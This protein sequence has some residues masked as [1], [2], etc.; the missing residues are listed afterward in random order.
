MKAKFGHA[1]VT[2]NRISIQNRSDKHNL[3]CILKIWPLKCP[4]KIR[5][6]FISIFSIF[7]RDCILRQY[8]AS[9]RRDDSGLFRVRGRGHLEREP[10]QR[11]HRPA[12]VSRNFQNRPIRINS[13]RALNDEILNF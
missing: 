8:E 13:I 4:I 2:H 9:V 1:K 6:A 10:G 11:G 5:M 7:E 3:H 12:E